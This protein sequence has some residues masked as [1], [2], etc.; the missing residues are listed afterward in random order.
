MVAR[1]VFE[2]L[3]FK[4]EKDKE[5]KDVVKVTFYNIYS[6]RLS[7]DELSEIGGFSI[8]EDGKSLEFDAPEKKAG[9]K[10]Y[11]LLQKAFDSLT[12]NLTGK[13]TI[14]VHKNSGI[15]IIG[16]GVF[17]LIDR[18][19]NC[20][21]VKP[22]T[23]CNLDCVFC[24]VDAGPS[25]RKNVDFVVE[26]EY[27]VEEFGKLV[28]NKQHDVEAHIGPQGEPLLYA[29]LVQLIRD[30]RKNQK[31]KVI[32]IDTNGTMLTRK[33]IDDFAEAGLTRLNVSLQAM[34]E[35]K[36]C[37]MAGRP[38]KVKYV[39]EMIEYA[40]KRMNVLIAPVIIPSLN[41]SEVEGLI[42]VGK[43]IKSDYPT[44]GVQ[45][46]LNYKRGR[47]PVKQRS[48]EEFYRMLEQYE[49]ETGAKLKLS[50]EDFGIVADAKLEKPF[51]KK[52]VVKALIVCDGPEADERI[53]SFKG[54]AI[55]V[56]KAGHLQAG[57][58]ARVEIIRDK[59]NI[60]RGIAR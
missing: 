22:L 54:R 16:E 32:S 48:W 39:L 60:F 41:D 52:D 55:I 47:N 17:G 34:D 44:V 15:P 30:L 20:I 49:Q 37:E 53:A 31:V 2:N 21:E 28:T 33:L 27:L 50:K 46:Y 4:E 10:F 40:S 18:N 12:C 6:C 14:Y 57:R 11:P 23:C 9:N 29:P 25:S 26:E 1:L 5:G 38:Y 8:G 43:N 36:A 13:R 58:E 56:G 3:R 7:S 19:T 24:S 59:H 45:N 42:G 51:K 35:K